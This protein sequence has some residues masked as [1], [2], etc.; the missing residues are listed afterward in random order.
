MAMPDQMP[1]TPVP[2][3]PALT[4]AQAREIYRQ[5]EEAVVFALLALA[6]QRADQRPPRTPA[7]AP[8]TPSAVVPTFLKPPAD[9]R[10]K[11]LRHTA[12][13]P[14]GDRPPCRPSPRSV[15]DL[16][17][18]VDADQP[19]SHPHHRGHPRGDHPGRHRA[20]DPPRLVPPVSEGRRKRQGVPP[21]EYASRR[22]RLT[23]RLDELIATAWEDRQARRLIKRLRRYR[24]DLFRFLDRPEVPFD[25]NYAE[26]AIRPAVIIRNSTVTDFP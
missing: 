22:A 4:E 3:G 9:A 18:A 12:T 23:A 13:D 24:D 15:A 1:P 7:T 20:H 14:R 6:K 2:L 21:E 26:R 17:G 5:G 10:R 19:G 11:C 8:A 16:P 25:N